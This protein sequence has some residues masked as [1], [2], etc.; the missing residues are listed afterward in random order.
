MQLHQRQGL[1][2]SRNDGLVV[3][4]GRPSVLLLWNLRGDWKTRQD[5]RQEDLIIEEV[6][7]I[8]LQLPRRVGYQW[9]IGLLTPMKKKCGC[10]RRLLLIL[11]QPFTLPFP[12]N[13]LD[14]APTPLLPPTWTWRDLKPSNFPLPLEPHT[15]HL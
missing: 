9:G 4:K 14:R 5:G 6:H 3:A 8:R 15:G 13:F 2:S 1:R 10:S 12:E 7:P 11:Q